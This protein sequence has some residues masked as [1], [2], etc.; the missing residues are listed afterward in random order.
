MAHRNWV[1]AHL[2]ILCIH[3]GSHCYPNITAPISIAGWL[4]RFNSIKKKSKKYSTQRNEQHLCKNM[5][6][7]CFRW[8]QITF[9]LHFIFLVR[10]VRCVRSFVSSV[11]P[12]SEW[13]LHSF[14]FHISKT[15]SD[16][17]KMSK[18]KIVFRV[19][20]FGRRAS[21]NSISHSLW[22]WNNEMWP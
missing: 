1:T 15:Y 18:L 20:I 2:R 12:S 11:S 7:I 10:C 9:D 17:R 6:T 4:N 16:V 22:L 5:L 3:F 14:F 8:W 13:N 19:P 21:N